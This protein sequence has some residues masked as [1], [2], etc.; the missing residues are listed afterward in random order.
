MTTKIP[1]VYIQL[2]KDKEKALLM[3][4][5]GAEISLIKKSS[6]PNSIKPYPFRL[7]LRGICGGRS[8]TLGVIKCK[9]GKTTTIFHVVEDEGQFKCD[10]ILGAEFFRDNNSSIS[11]SDQKLQ[12]ENT[13]IDFVPVAKTV[14]SS[15]E[16]INKKRKEY[17]NDNI[18]KYAE[19]PEIGINI[20]NPSENSTIAFREKLQP[21]SK[22]TNVELKNRLENLEKNI[23]QLKDTLEIK[24]RLYKIEKQIQYMDERNVVKINESKRKSQRFQSQNS[25]RKNNPAQKN[26]Q[27]ENVQSEYDINFIDMQMAEYDITMEEMNERT[28]QEKLGLYKPI[29]LRFCKNIEFNSPKIYHN[30][31][32]K[33]RMDEILKLANL[34]EL[35]K[36]EHK[37]LGKVLEKYKDSIYLKGDTWDGVS[38]KLGYHRINLKTE[39]PVNIKQYKLPYKLEQIVDNQIEE[40]LKMGVI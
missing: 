5:S 20:V 39:E 28:R 10:G 32:G 35:N 40:W 12:L 26:K 16:L 1:H 29:H 6:I 4:D 8:L 27:R 30:I 18:F 7:I 19:I 9:I 17:Q 13:K 25:Q 3:I 37:A 23:S 22:I 36:L 34:K 14:K 38:A 2:C 24:T 11:F 33:T 15:M 31:V 21:N